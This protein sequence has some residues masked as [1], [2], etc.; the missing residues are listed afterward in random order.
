VAI[1]QVAGGSTGPSFGLLLALPLIVLVL[2]P[3]L[4]WAGAL[5]G[6]ATVPGGVLTLL[7]E[8]RGLSDAS[9][10]A[11]LSTPVTSLA[12]MG[13]IGFRRV[14][15]SEL[16]AQQERAE[17]LER[18]SHADRLAMVGTLAAGVAHEINNP[19]SYLVSNIRCALGGLPEVLPPASSAPEVEEILQALRDAELG[20]KRIGHIV[21][22]LKLMS[23]GPT[24]DEVGPVD[25]RAVIEGATTIAASEVRQRARLVSELAEVPSVKGNEFRLGQVFLN[26]LVNAAQSI[27]PGSPAAHQVTVRV[28]QRMGLGRGER[29][30]PR[31]PAGSPRA[32]L[33]AVL[34]HQASRPGDGARAL[35]EHEHGQGLRWLHRGGERG[36]PGDDLS[37][38]PGPCGGRP[39]L[40]PRPRPPPELPR[41]GLAHDWMGATQPGQRSGRAMGSQAGPGVPPVPAGIRGGLYT[42]F[43]ERIE[44]AVRSN[45]ATSALVRDISHPIVVRIEG[46]IDEWRGRANAAIAAARA[47][48]KA[49]ESAAVQRF[50]GVL[51]ASALVF[52][53]A[54]LY[55]SRSVAKPLAILT[56]GAAV[57]GR[58]DLGT[59]IGIDTPDEFGSLAS[60]I[61]ALAVSIQDQQTR[62]VESEQL[63]GIGRVAAGIAQEI[64]SPLQVAL[65]HLSRYRDGGDPRLAA[66]EEEARRCKQIVDGM[67][68]LSRPRAHLYPGPVDLRT[69]CEE[70]SASL[71]ALARPA[72]VRIAVDGA[73]SA[74]A[75]R[76]R[77]RLAVFNLVKNAVEAAGYGGQVEVRI[78]ESTSGPSIR[79]SDTGPGVPPEL[80]GRL[81]EPLF[82]AK[83][84]GSG[85]GLAVSR[86]VVRAHGGDVDLRESGER[87]AVFQLHLPRALS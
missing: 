42:R 41:R 8:G 46:E 37:G 16:R 33:R 75:D 51:L 38:A 73:G 60:D 48:L 15:L 54:V 68:E 56:Q 43:R 84:S 83:E 86:S 50:A 10:W 4:P 12:V 63:A 27:P 76:S 87:G 20:A 6:A 61:I 79:V 53:G 80:K 18:L 82:T 31:H 70:V 2:A 85:L 45:V 55:L 78:L 29:H 1:I 40:R 13:A 3:E 35:P 17:A 9:E 67:L 65:G 66:V 30:R 77:L 57:L 44:P 7:Q 32:P 52:A 11:C 21:K 36:R 26:L 5:A 19:L 58:G 59:R 74:L 25:L 28:R 23:R 64:N 22:D 69:L 24:S 14:W 47:D 34:H 81:F 71:L 49:Q 62:L 39:T 72:R